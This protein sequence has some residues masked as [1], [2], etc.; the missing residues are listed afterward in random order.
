MTDLMLEVLD[1]TFSPPTTRLVGLR[2]AYSSG[3]V[4]IQPTPT[5]V[6]LSVGSNRL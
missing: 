1:G 6:R 2:D 5:G 3:L 4:R